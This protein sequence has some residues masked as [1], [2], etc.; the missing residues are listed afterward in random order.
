[1]FKTTG[2]TKPVRKTSRTRFPDLRLEFAPEAQAE[3]ESLQV[4][5]ACPE[6]AVLFEQGSA[7]MGLFVVRRGAVRL[8]VHRKGKADLPV[9]VAGKGEAVGVIGTMSNQPYIGTA[10]AVEPGEIAFVPR[11]PF[12]EFLERHPEAR[13]KVLEFL[14]REVSGAYQHVRALATAKLPRI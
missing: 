9:R 10:V 2:R 7:P 3:F 5:S 6:G 11:V 14:T 8:S 12:L 13:L 1:M 4:R